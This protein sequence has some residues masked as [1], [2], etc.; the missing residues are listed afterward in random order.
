MPERG[1]WELEDVS[2]KR[3]PG[4]ELREAILPQAR[5]A[6]EARWKVFI[7]NLNFVLFCGR[8]FV[9]P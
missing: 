8:M 2:N 6:S 9:W 5:A 4:G 1:Q 7:F 3:R